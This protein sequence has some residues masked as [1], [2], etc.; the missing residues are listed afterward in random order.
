MIECPATRHRLEEP[1]DKVWSNVYG[2]VRSLPVGKIRARLRR[3]GLLQSW[4]HRLALQRQH[5]EH[6]LVHPPLRFAPN[7]PLQPLDAERELAERE[8]PLGGQP[9]AGA[10]MRPSGEWLTQHGPAA[11][12]AGGPE[13]ILPPYCGMRPEGSHQK[14]LTNLRVPNGEAPGSKSMFARWERGA[15]TVNRR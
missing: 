14:D 4:V 7:E 13:P 8:R 1:A 11:M 5:S 3:G 9:P 10:V 6:T 15:P 12:P 2:H